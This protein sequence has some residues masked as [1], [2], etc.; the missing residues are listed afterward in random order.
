MT[1]TRAFVEAMAPD[2]PPPHTVGWDRPGSLERPVR[3]GAAITCAAVAAGFFVSTAVTGPATPRQVA[4]EYM[5]ARYDQDWSAVW[6]LTCDSIR[7]STDFASFAEEAAFIHK[8]YFQP[9]DA[10]I[11]I[12][13][14]EFGRNGSAEYLKVSAR[15]TADQGFRQ[16]AFDGDLALALEDGKFRVCGPG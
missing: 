8:Y 11:S 9:S 7:D 2:R 6:A 5:E 13:D 14:I 3:K 10:D 1:V 15:A 4:A 16:V 12:G